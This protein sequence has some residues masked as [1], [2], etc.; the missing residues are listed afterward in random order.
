M[1]LLI[2]MML[3]PC[4]GWLNK[5]YAQPSENFPPHITLY[6][7]EVR[8]EGF[9]LGSFTRLLQMDADLTMYREGLAVA[10]SQLD[11]CMDRVLDLA[12][13]IESS[14]RL[15]VALR[16]ERSRLVGLLATATESRIEA[17]NSPNILGVVGW[18]V[19]IGLAIST[20]VLASVLAISGV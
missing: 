12:D 5:A 6:S 3:M 11:Y 18:V 9:D 2:G 1:G 8:Y 20:I 4:L 13:A 15:E 14:E 10:S 19:S 7:D 16:T 17:E